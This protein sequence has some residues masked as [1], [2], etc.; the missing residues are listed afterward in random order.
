MYSIRD[1]KAECFNT[2]FFKTTHGEAER[3]FRVAVNDENTSLNQFPDDFDLYF[4]GT[5]D[6]NTGRLT[7]LDTPQHVIKAVR[8]LKPKLQPTA[9]I[10][11]SQLRN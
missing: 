4:V 11:V 9:E 1:Q 10:P 7:S 5:Y 2:P 3:D 8:C 6:T